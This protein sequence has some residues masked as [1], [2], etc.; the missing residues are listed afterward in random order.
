MEKRAMRR[1]DKALIEMAQLWA[2]L[3]KAEV[4]TLCFNDEGSP[5]GVPL[6][7]GTGEDAL[8]IHCAREGRKWDLLNQAKPIFFLAWCDAKLKQGE[9]ACSYSMRY[10]SIMGTAFPVLLEDPDEKREGLNRIMHKY[11]GRSD[12][13]FPDKSLEAT[14]IFRLE[15]TSM[16]GK[17]SGY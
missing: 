15:I 7:F 1:G 16:T 13:A 14:G 5:Y 2:V 10:R 8:F 4:L 11:T 12:F 17:A 6:S 9:A 3:D